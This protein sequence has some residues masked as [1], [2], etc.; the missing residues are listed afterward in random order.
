MGRSLLV[1]GTY[2]NREGLTSLN[3][4]N[5]VKFSGEKKVK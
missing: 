2:Q 3:A 1:L 4:N 5:C